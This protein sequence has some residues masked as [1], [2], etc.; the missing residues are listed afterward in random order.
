MGCAQNGEMAK[1]LLS[2]KSF[3]ALVTNYRDHLQ[4][5][6][7]D[8]LRENL[9]DEQPVSGESYTI[10]TIDEYEL[11]NLKYLTKVLMEFS[12]YVAYGFFMP[13]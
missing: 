1:S 2:A 11:F 5:Y 4:H 6:D 3:R 10:L 12:M 7:H 9:A 8:D 13:E